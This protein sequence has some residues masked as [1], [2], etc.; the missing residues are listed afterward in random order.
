[1][2]KTVGSRLQRRKRHRSNEE[3]TSQTSSLPSPIHG[4]CLMVKNKKKKKPK[5]VESEE[6][7]DDEC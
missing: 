7:E 1:M 3:S 2:T 6:E 5:K 4:K